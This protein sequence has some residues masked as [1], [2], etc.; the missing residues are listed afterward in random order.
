[1]KNDLGLF[2]ECQDC[3]FKFKLRPMVYRYECSN[4]DI[5]IFCPICQSNNVAIIDRKNYE[6]R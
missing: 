5:D 2:R 4:M 3:K 6:K 1:M